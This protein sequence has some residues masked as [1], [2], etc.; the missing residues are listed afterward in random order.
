MSDKFWI[1]FETVEHCLSEIRQKI[2]NTVADRRIRI[3][4]LDSGI[5]TK[6]PKVQGLIQQT[7]SW[8][9][10]RLVFKSLTGLEDDSDPVGHGTHIEDTIMS[11]AQGARIYVGG[12]VDQRGNLDP[13]A[14]AKVGSKSL[15]ICRLLTK[16]GFRPCSRGM[17]C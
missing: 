7:S 9:S 2:N 3:A 8:N 17:A 5:N 16:E 11:I 14:L 1:Y 4:V 12:V 6:H 10:N 13:N 15:T